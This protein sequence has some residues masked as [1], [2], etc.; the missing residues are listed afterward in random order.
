VKVDGEYGIIE[1]VIGGRTR[2]N[3]DVSVPEVEKNP[4][5]TGSVDKVPTPGDYIEV[6][7]KY[8]IVESSRWTCSYRF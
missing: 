2:V 1:A 3:F 7:G 8:G 4:I 5:R 6:D